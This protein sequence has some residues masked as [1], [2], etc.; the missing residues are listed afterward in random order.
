MVG[1]VASGAAQAC[2]GAGH[3]HERDHMPHIVRLRRVRE[4]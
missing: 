1:A 3:R 2:A 4:A